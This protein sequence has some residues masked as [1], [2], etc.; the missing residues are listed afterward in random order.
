[1]DQRTEIAARAAEPHRPLDDREEGV[2]AAERHEPFPSREAR[3]IIR[4]LLEP[5]ASIYWADLLFHVALGWTAFVFALSFSLFSAG[6]IL[7]AAVS[8]LALYRSA[9]FIHELAHRKE[10]SFDSFRLVWNLLC[11]FPL[12]T[13]SFT[14]H[15][16]HN[17]HHS[18]DVYGT[19]ND[20]EYVSF[21]LKGRAEIVGYFFL[22]F[23]LPI[24]FAVRFLV[25]SPL[26]RLHPGLRQWVWERASSLAIDLSY[27][28]RAASATE[29]RVRRVQETAPF[30]YGVTVI[31][32]VVIGVLPI[33]LPLLWYLIAVSIFLLN[34]L[35]TLAAHRYRNP[36]GHVMS[37][38]EQ[39]LDSVD[40]PG[41]PF[42]TALW[43]PVGLRYHA[44]HHLFPGI[45]YHALGEAHRRLA[46]GLSDNAIYLAATR[47]GLW[48]ALGQLWRDA[49][50]NAAPPLSRNAPA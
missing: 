25:L 46:G 17:D 27:R 45:P 22:S 11:G 15:G 44:T 34:S 20:G 26:S 3:E 39:F 1:V 28:R 48:D 2:V 18:R 16:V 43:A 31:T 10:K 47:D 42:L 49:G 35:R 40:V 30:L 38:E 37:R 50:S 29:M 24:V 6:Q 36:E 23:A 19:K 13:P 9:I 7:S 41:N 4:D 5:R 21:V 14:Y 33:G 8:A 12:L 32:L